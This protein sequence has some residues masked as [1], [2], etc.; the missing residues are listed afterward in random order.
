MRRPPCSPRRSASGSRAT[1]P[2]RQ[3]REG[4]VGARSY[5]GVVATGKIVIHG[6]REHNLRNVHLELPRDRLIVFTG[7][8]G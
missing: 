6:A 8:S 1:R 3:A 7:L 2:R 5:N 4:R